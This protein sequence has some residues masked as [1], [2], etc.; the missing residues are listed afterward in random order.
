M[1]VEARKARVVGDGLSNVGIVAK[2]VETIDGVKL[3][4]P[5][6]VADCQRTLEAQDVVQ[7]LC[8]LW[9]GHPG[10]ARGT[11]TAGELRVELAAWLV[12]IASK[13]DARRIFE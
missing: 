5:Y 2:L 4:G 12:T 8:A 3:G 1:A 10:A 11:E 9:V 6:C 7:V 13:D